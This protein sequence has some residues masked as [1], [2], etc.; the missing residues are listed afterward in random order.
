MER[1][2]LMTISTDEDVEE[3]ILKIEV[4]MDRFEG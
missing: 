4:R 1:N 2:N 3:N